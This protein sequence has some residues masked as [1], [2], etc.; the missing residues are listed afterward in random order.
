MERANVSISIER[1]LAVR[2]S[3]KKMIVPSTVVEKIETSEFDLEN[4]MEE[5][6]NAFEGKCLVFADRD[7]KDESYDA[8]I[9]RNVL[10]EVN[11]LLNTING[12]FMEV[13]DRWEENS[14]KEDLLVVC[15]DFVEF[16][17][18]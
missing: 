2:K 18:K 1:E 9:N 14:K 4:M 10:S 15:D 12:S 17:S 11:D 7:C 6:V 8:E 13:V 3:K 16:K 5:T